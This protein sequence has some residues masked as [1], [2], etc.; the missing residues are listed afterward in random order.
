MEN[1]ILA[2]TVALVAIVGML[3]DFFKRLFKIETK[4]LNHLISWVISIAATYVAWIIGYIPAVTQP[5]WLWILIEGIGV[6][7]IANGVYTIDV[8]KKVYDF[9]FSFINGKLYFLDKKDDNK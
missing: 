1:V 8:V 3:T 9:I 7:L 6:G 4:W 5:E 2:A